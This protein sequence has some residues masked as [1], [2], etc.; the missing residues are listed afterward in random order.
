MAG[1]AGYPR[2][3]PENKNPTNNPMALASCESKVFARC[4]APVKPP[5]KKSR[6]KTPK[7]KKQKK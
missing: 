6:K 4:P 1:I 7:K 3:K 5:A 2:P